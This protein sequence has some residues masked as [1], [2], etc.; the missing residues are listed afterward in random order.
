MA[1]C[2]CSKKTQQP[3]ATEPTES[4]QKPVIEGDDVF[5]DKHFQEM[6]WGYYEASVYHYTGN[7]AADTEAFRKDMQ[8]LQIASPYGPL[9][10][11]AL[12]LDIQMGSYSQFMSTFSYGEKY[13]SA[14]TETGRAMFRKFY[15]EKFGELTAEGFQKVEKLL[16]RNVA[17]VTFVQPGGDTQLRL[18]AYEIQEDVLTLY[19]FSVDEQYNETV[20][21]AFA[22]YYFLQD[23]GKLILDYSGTRREYLANGYKGNLRIAG[24]AQDQSKQYNNLEGFAL[25]QKPE[26]EG[27]Q[28]DVILSNDARP[29][30]PSVT[31]DKTTGDFSLTWTKSTYH[32]G[33]IQH[34]SP[35]QISGKL[36]P[37]TGYGFNGF[38]GFYLLVDGTCYSYLVSE[39][40]Y[41]ERRYANVKNADEI[42]DLRREALARVKISA[43]SELEQ[44]YE[45]AELSVDIDFTRGQIS[46]ANSNLFAA[47]SQAVSEEGREFLRQFMEIYAS[48]IQ[49]EDYAEYISCIMIESHT[50][51]GV[52][53]E[54]QALS[55]SLAD[56]VA[57][58]CVDLQPNLGKEIQFTGCAYDYPIYNAD[59]SVNA[60]DS[61]RIVFRFLLSDE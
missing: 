53:S 57:K 22:Q 24:Y 34:T 39:E 42:S 43:L 7:S 5:G 9:Q 56:A 28:I 36:I 2:G 27:Y 26:G 1:F 52:Y 60:E 19:Q 23:G 38:S 10:I 46:I 20:G 59:G 25:T 17:Q 18:F 16:N 55:V 32:S 31:F 50:D 12:P 45:Q 44:A 3:P 30:D 48:V 47:D 29:V 15:I 21:A 35:R 61:N 4:V 54:Q 6:L 8:Y 51:V 33:E 37:C 11:S 13:Y 14:Y 41:K 49:K 40:E 58:S